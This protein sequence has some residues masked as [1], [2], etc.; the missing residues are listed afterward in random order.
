[1]LLS[2]SA[3]ACL[4]LAGHVSAHPV[5]DV[6]RERQTNREIIVRQL[7][8]HKTH[9]RRATASAYPYSKCLPSPN[10]TGSSLVFANV[11]SVDFEGSRGTD[12]GTT[13]SMT[14]CALNCHFSPTCKESLWDYETHHCYFQTSYELINTGGGGTGSI[15]LS[16]SCADNVD[17]VPGT[18]PADCCN[19]YI[20]IPP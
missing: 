9:P 5:D 10:A 18:E 14:D 7:E 13:S 2:L 20:T 6:V 11:D 15:F 8:A 4:V 1:M 19:Y 3:L 16:G 17:N 12:T